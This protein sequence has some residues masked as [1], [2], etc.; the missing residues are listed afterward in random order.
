[1]IVVCCFLF[2]V[3]VCDVVAHNKCQKHIQFNDESASFDCHLGMF[4][5]CAM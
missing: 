3:V 5:D 4:S 2:V 1:M